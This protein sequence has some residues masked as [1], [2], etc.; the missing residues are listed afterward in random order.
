M[1]AV[2]VLTGLLVGAVFGYSSRP[3]GAAADAGGQ[4]RSGG[5]TTTSTPPDS[6]WTVVMAS[7]RSREEADRD[8]ATV[9]ARGVEDVFVVGQGQYQPLGTRYAVCS[10]HFDSQKA[11]ADHERQLQP[12]KIAGPPYKKKLSRVQAS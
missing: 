6:F 10:G 11:A 7:P 5:G 1:L 3:S 4:A 12:Y 8:A 2:A 9:S